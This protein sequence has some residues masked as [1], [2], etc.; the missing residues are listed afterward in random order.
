MERENEREK[1]REKEEGGER[2]KAQVGIATC[3]QP[4]PR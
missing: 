1:E 2:K 4:A 3:T